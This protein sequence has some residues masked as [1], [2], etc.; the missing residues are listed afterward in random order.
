MTK[1]QLLL[2]H[3]KLL[4]ELAALREENLR[5]RLGESIPAPRPA[6]ID[7]ILE[8]SPSAQSQFSR[9]PLLR[10]ADERDDAPAPTEPEQKKPAK[11]PPLTLLQ[12]AEH[13]RK[14]AAAHFGIYAGRALYASFLGCMAASD[15]ILLRSEDESRS[16]L[17]LCQAVASALGET[18]SLTTVHPQWSSAADLL[19][20]PEPASKL[21]RE[22]AFLRRLYAAGYEE[23]V[24]F[25]ALERVTAAPAE[26]YLSTLLPLLAFSQA[27]NP[28]FARS[29]PLADSA[30]P[31]DPFLL[32]DGALPY[33]DNLWLFGS[34]A[35]GDPLPGERLRGVAMEFC[36]PVLREKSYLVSL[37][38]P[39]TLSAGQLREHFDHAAEVF[40]LPGEA[41]RCFQQTARY[42]ADFMDLSLGPA[43]ETQLM[44]FS[45]VCLA[46]G[47]RPAE[48][49]DSYFYHKALRRLETLDANAL[50][51]GL[52][53]LRR[54][55]S[56]TFAARD[57]PL[58]MALLDTMENAAKKPS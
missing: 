5:L 45:S 24:C 3:K 54:H 7:D 16:A 22:T 25:A 23:G 2:E 51:L 26:G 8:E 35:A 43:A 19:G 30:W 49:L 15:F 27:E 52:P 56:E 47:L 48:A 10:A 28:V 18:P 20:A 41:L 36:L 13:L 14:Y 21:Y 9:F 55:F 6:T 42:L 50:Q 31:G 1:K 44:Q 57:V 38:K 34:I 53:G 58:T 40:A 32:Q 46:C 12:L 4:A 29:I 33:P 17:L 11:R 37:A 39:M